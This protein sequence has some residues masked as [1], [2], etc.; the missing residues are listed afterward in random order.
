MKS[1]EWRKDKVLIIDQRKLPER[2]VYLEIK[3]H[4]HMADA[5][6][7]MAIRGAPALGIAAAMGLALC[8]LNSK[9]KPGEALIKELEEAAALI[10]K[11]RPTA[12]NLFWALERMMTLTNDFK[13]NLEELKKRL[14]GEALEIAREDEEMCRKI[15]DFGASLVE[16]NSS[17]LTHCNAGG[18]AT[19]GYGTALGVIRS[20]Y[21]QDKVLNVYVDETRP[22]LQGAR[23]TAWELA[24]EG[25]PFILITDNMAGFLMKKGKIDLVVVGADR[26]AANGDVAN[27]IGTYSVAVLANKHGIPFYVAAP[28]STVDLSIE[29]GEDIPIEERNPEEI[30][31][32][33]SQVV[34]APQG[35]T[36]FNP[37][38]DVTDHELITA[39]ITE[40]GIIKPPFDKGLKEKNHESPLSGGV[41]IA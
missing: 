15:G 25:I 20:S 22:L 19:G 34:V 41:K 26:I 39:I 4:F 40:R 10:R 27:K 17:F 5:I 12:V 14:V 16:K 23:L 24:K 6:K 38:F 32:I 9:A 3:D 18:L 8:A 33:Q 11:T 31:N 29:S 21:A 7:T 1:I 37:A 36:V 35:T 30:T 13:G 2:E 28:F